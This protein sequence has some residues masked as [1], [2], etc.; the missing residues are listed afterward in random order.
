MRVHVVHPSEL[1]SGEIASWH[2][3]QQATP[4][5]AHP[6]LS[7]EFAIAVGRFRP[8]SRVAILTEDQRTAGFFAFERRRLGV[9][10]PIAGWLSACQGVIH[11]PDVQWEAAE[12]LRGCGLAAWRFDNLIADQARLNGYRCAIV[13][14]PV[15]DI[16]EGF[17]AYYAKL[18]VRASRFCRELDRKTRKLSR[19]NGEL[20]LV[21][22]A[23]D[24]SLLRL[25]MTWKSEQYR[26]TD[27]VDRFDRPWVA[28]LLETLLTTRTENMAGLLSVLYAGDQPVSI[29]FGLRAGGLLVGWFTGY[30]LRFSKYSPGLIQIRQ[31]AEHL[32]SIGVEMLQMG[33]GARS[34]TE[35][36]KNGDVLVGEGIITGHSLLGAAHSI[37]SATEQR[38]LNAV[39]ERPALH[40]AADRVLRRTGVSSRTYGRI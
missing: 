36:L 20:R 15:I 26:R 6:F 1:G 35:E 23:E 12:L 21:C 28:E 33:K 24:S 13:P 39:R 32:G 19:E 31:M 40:R 11:E 2:Q 4:S 9:A 3:M 29:Q 17:D 16:S 10:L 14:Y 7:P 5:L 37:R 27:H 25:L 8:D 22:D 30:D 18:R 38:A 34:F